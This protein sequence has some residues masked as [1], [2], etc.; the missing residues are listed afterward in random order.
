MIGHYFKIIATQNVH[1]E[2]RRQSGAL[3]QVH[4]PNP[5]GH[6]IVNLEEHTHHR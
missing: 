4:D 2:R 3:P 5:I 1:P 6:N